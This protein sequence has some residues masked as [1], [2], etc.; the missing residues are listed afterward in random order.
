MSHAMRFL[1]SLS[2]HSV[3]GETF[4]APPVAT[5]DPSLVLHTNTPLTHSI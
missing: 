4:I 2:G 1:L 3:S 5:P